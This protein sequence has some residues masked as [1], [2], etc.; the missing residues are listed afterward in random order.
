MIL[1]ENGCYFFDFAYHYPY[2]KELHSK[3]IKELFGEPFNTSFKLT[4]SLMKADIIFTFINDTNCIKVTSLLNPNETIL[5]IDPL[6][7]TIELTENQREEIVSFN[8]IQFET[9][10]KNRGIKYPTVNSIILTNQLKEV[11]FDSV[12]KMKLEIKNIPLEIIFS[13]PREENNVFGK[14]SK[15]IS[16]YM[17]TKFKTKDDFPENKFF[18]E[19]DFLIKNEENFDYYYSD[20]DE[21]TEI[22]KYLCNIEKKGKTYFMTGP[23]GIGKTF[24]LLAFITINKPKEMRYIYLNLD[25]LKNENN[26]M[27]IFFYEARNLF[28]NLE[29][30]INAFKYVQENL[31]MASLKNQRANIFNNLKDELLS[32]VLCLIEYIDLNKSK[33]YPNLRFSIIIDQFKYINDD[34]YNCKL[35]IKLKNIIETKKSFSL[36]VCSSLNYK[37]IKNNLIN[38]ISNKGEENKFDFELEN[39]ICNKPNMTNNNE[40]LDLLGYLPIYCQNQ[41]LINKKYINLMKKI[42]KK[43][44][45]KFY[46]NIFLNKENYAED[47][48]I[49]RLKLIKK[50]RNI[51]L[52]NDE[53]IEFMMQNP[54]KYFNIYLDKL[55][56]DYLFPLIGII[57]D[58]IINS[59]ELR[60]SYIGSLNEAQKGW[61][62]EHLL[63]DTIKKNNF[64]HNYYIENSILIKTVF[65]KEIIKNFDKNSNTLF[66]FTI[67]NV[68]RYDGVIYI[69]EDDNIILTQVL[70]NKPKRK[71]DEYTEKNMSQEITK[72]QK[73]FISNGIFPKKYFLV[74]ILD[75][76]N[77]YGD[78]EKLEIFRQ[79]KYNYCFFNPNLDEIKYEFK[80]MKEIGY[81]PYESSEEEDKIGFLFCK[82]KFFEII[83][84]E[85]IE[86]KPGYYYAEKGMDLITFL[87]ETCNEY[88]GLIEFLSK[89]K[90][91]YLSYKLKSFQKNFFSITKYNELTSS[92]KERIVIALNDNDLLFGISYYNNKDLMIDY[93]WQKWSYEIYGFSG[94][95]LN[96]K[97]KNYVSDI[98]GFFIFE[99]IKR[100]L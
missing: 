98:E 58:E 7:L 50:K 53:M 47:F 69:A 60:K 22:I 20:G 34:E 73:F 11:I 70:I 93:N 84:D 27:M 55:K 71:L 86:Y 80:I 45:F 46:S 56:F 62:F 75:F 10:L 97:E 65:K 88:N 99:N 82:N 92:T 78:D 81:D 23:H 12:N 85:L 87:E 32:I 42:I 28:D 66:Y 33:K 77:Y 35:I 61:Y 100:I 52:S 95:N 16:L 1:S 40:F 36:I 89:D 91:S 30:Y 8:D 54:I 63:F 64:F 17:K 43:K 37:A 9:I 94:N 26:N 31:K 39:K 59:Y 5:R 18:T 29:E 67:N 2:T 96:E 3:V 72:M 4:Y 38:S 51:K 57:I 49:I 24:T 79:Y 44:F 14:F 68:K 83:K 76:K 74:F 19:K 48:M 13:E 15:Y 25:I 41:K 6:E 90:N 21:R